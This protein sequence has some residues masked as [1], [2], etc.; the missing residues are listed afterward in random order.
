MSDPTLRTGDLVSCVGN[1]EG[2]SDLSC[3]TAINNSII[4][5]EIPHDTERIM[6]G[7]F[8]F[9]DNLVLAYALGWGEYHL[10]ASSDKDGDSA[11]IRTLLNHQHSIPRRAK[12]QLPHKPSLPQFLCR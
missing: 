4:L 5:D 1:S 2:T 9:V 12:L 10:I 3:T 8:G 6:Q 7:P 11:G